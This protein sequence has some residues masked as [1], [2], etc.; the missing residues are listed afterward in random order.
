MSYS[1]FRP[2]QMSTSHAFAGTAMQG[3]LTQE[4]GYPGILVVIALALISLWLDGK[5]YRE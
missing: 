4:L 3:S 1:Q 5:A 2:T